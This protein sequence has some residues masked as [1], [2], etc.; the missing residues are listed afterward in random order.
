M[1]K[2]VSIVRVDTRPYRVIAQE[3]WGLTKEQMK[4][5]HVHHRIKR[6][7]GGTNDPSNLYVCSEWFH[8]NI[9]HAGEGGFTG[10]ASKGGSKT[11]QMKNENGKSI[12]ASASMTK[13]HE[14]KNKEGKSLLALKIN[15][16]N[17]AEKDDNGKS[18][19][20]K[21]AGESSSRKSRKW[22]EL[23]DSRG[24]VYIFEGLRYACDTL[25]LDVGT[26]HKI[27][28]KKRKSHKGFTA[29]YIELP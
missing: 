26:I 28:C 1:K 5:M 23:T 29:K 7:D 27:C 22:V 9:W 14:R 13:A 16:A 25:G 15:K 6:C 4:G 3:N 19:L 10:C 11:H 21:K 8:D 18:V 24:D 2:E 20:A 17:H 12:H